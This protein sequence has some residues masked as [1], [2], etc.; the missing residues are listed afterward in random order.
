MSDP[1]LLVDEG[2]EA[3]HFGKARGWNFHVESAGQMQRFEV[4]HPGEGGLIFV[5]LA[6]H[7]DR[8]F[9]LAGALERPVM[10]R[11]NAFDDFDRIGGCKRNVE[12]RH[13]VSTS[14]ERMMRTR[15]HSSQTGLPACC[16][17]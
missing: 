3:L 14:A 13:A 5:P 15:N 9:I 12:K 4:V 16:S 11:S 2:D 1:H 6:L 17:Q 7:D 8:D 10:R